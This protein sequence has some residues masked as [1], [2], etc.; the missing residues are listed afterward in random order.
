MAGLASHSPATTSKLFHGNPY[1]PFPLKIPRKKVVPPKYHAFKF[2]H[3][4]FPPESL[5][6]KFFAANFFQQNV[7][8]KFFP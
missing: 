8:A 3:Q 6:H 7:S 5:L 2:F 1:F 4:N